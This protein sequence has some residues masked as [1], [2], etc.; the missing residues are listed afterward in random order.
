MSEISDMQARPYTGIRRWL[1]PAAVML[2]AIPLFALAAVYDTFPGDEAAL[3]ALQDLRTG[4]LDATAIT[5]TRSADPPAAL[6]A[7]T[8]AAAAMLVWGRWTAAVMLA[9]TLAPTLCSYV[10]KELAA[11]P[12]PEY[13]IMGLDPA[14]FSFPSGHAVFA[15][16]FGGCLIYLAGG[17]WPVVSDRPLND[18][19]LRRSIQ[20][21]LGLWSLSVG[22]SR[23]YLGVHW[24]SDVVGGFLLGGLALLIAISLK[25]C[26]ETS[27]SRRTPHTPKGSRK[28][29]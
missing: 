5:I 27:L 21:L 9:F 15:A 8:I 12:R 1:L 3:A 13:A 29:F 23:V 28:G 10:L 4:W 24:P 6:A 17:R 7:V 18:H 16:Y 20:I 19:W 26:L 2:C 14:T 25:H 22:V 11:R